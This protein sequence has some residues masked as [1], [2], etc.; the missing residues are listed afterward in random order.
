MNGYNFDWDII[1][2]MTEQGR[3]KRRVPEEQKTERRKRYQHE[4][5]LRVTKEK[6]RKQSANTRN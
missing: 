5:Y 1:P 6:R 3:H 4:Y 2:R